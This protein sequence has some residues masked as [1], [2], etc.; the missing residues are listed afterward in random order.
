MSISISKLTEAIFLTNGD[1][2]DVRIKSKN[3]DFRMTARVVLNPTDKTVDFW[4]HLGT[5]SHCIN[6]SD[7]EDA[8]IDADTYF[9]DDRIVR[10]EFIQFI[11]IGA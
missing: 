3:M 5:I 7:I 8:F 11:K 10:D 9:V 2:V 6:V 1:L 4:N